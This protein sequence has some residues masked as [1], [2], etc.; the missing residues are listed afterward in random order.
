MFKQNF[1]FDIC[2][3]IYALFEKVI[4]IQILLSVGIPR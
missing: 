2:S 3:S 1:R 4:K